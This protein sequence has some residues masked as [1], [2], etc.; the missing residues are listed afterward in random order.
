MISREQL[1]QTAR[2][3]ALNLTE[4]ELDSM[5]AE[6]TAILKLVDDI[7]VENDGELWGS[8]TC[9]ATRDD[10]V[11]PSVSAVELLQNA[12]LHT[13]DCFIYRNGKAQKV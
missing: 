10:T 6:M 2:L 3:A 12:P 13:E 5:T 8:D 4:S 1:Q 11:N 7:P 9:G